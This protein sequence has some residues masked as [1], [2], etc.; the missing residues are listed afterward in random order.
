MISFANPHLL[1]LLFILPVVAGLFIMAR[2]ARRRKLKRFG[3]PEV[4]EHLMP[5]ASKYMSWVKMILGLVIM[6]LMIVILARPR[7]NTGIG[8]EAETETVKARGIEVMICLDVSNSMLASATDDERGISRLQ[9]AKHILEKLIGKMSDDKIGLIV[10][11]GDAYTQLPITSDYISAKMFLNNISPEMVPTQGTNIGAAIDM[12][13][14]S[15][16]PDDKFPKAIVIITDGE[17]FE[18]DAVAA[19]RRA[20]ESGI[21]VDVIGMGSGKGVRIPMP[22]GKYLVN[23]ATGESVF[24]KLDEAT[25]VQIADA[26]KG[27][28]VNGA[29]SSVVTDVDNKLDELGETEYERK[30]FSPQSEQFPVIAFIVLI[31]M[32][33]YCITVTRKI[34]WLK[35]FEFFSN[36][37]EDKK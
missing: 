30:N 16:T 36:K 35:Q 12:A 33:I 14:N 18:E 1:Y 28:Y 21:Q 2:M 24:T 8:D 15:F 17:N 23:P 20:G 7:A 9:R 27:I 31:L 19:A 4:L 13:M 10:F 25:A 37:Q 3:N 6:A 26:G 22:G 34:S 11:A 29:V 5:E 32:V